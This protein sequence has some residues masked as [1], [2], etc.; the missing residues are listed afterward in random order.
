MSSY[1]WNDGKPRNT[2]KAK[3]SFIATEDE[4][5]IN[6]SPNGNS[7]YAVVN[8]DAKNKYGEAPGYRFM[9]GMLTLEGLLQSTDTL[10]C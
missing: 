8:K 7:M 4:A 1:V 10:M 3:K 5:K 6:W 2:M 9:P